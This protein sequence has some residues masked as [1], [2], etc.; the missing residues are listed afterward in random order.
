MFSALPVTAAHVY[1]RSLP[2]SLWLAREAV[3]ST[4]RVRGAVGASAL[5]GDDLKQHTADAS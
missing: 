5:V 4:G 2:W 1:A 3:R